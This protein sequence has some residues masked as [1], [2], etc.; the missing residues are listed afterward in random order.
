MTSN[1]SRSPPSARCSESTGP[2]QAY[3]RA[4]DRSHVLYANAEMPLYVNASNVAGYSRNHFPNGQ[5]IA[6]DRYTLG[7]HAMHEI[8]R[9]DPQNQRTIVLEISTR[10]GMYLGQSGHGSNTSHL[11]PR[12]LRLWVIGTGQVDYRRPDGTLG[13]R[14]IVQV[15]DT[16]PG[17]KQAFNCPSR[18]EAPMSTDDRHLISADAAEQTA[19]EAAI[20]SSGRTDKHG[21]PELLV[22]PFLISDV[23]H[24][25]LV[26]KADTNVDTGHGPK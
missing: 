1:N 9:T 14:T 15:T 13:R 26:P 12:G 6:F 21:R 22:H 11:M 3:E 18:T 20:P 5:E 7:T 2:I 25:R 8:E 23:A 4:N 24:P 17:P 19:W 10:R 16:P